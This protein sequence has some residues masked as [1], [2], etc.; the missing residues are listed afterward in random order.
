MIAYPHILSTILYTAPAHTQ[1]LTLTD[2]LLLIYTNTHWMD[3]YSWRVIARVADDVQSI[4]L[5][6]CL[7]PPKEPLLPSYNK[8][9]WS[10]QATI[11][12]QP[13]AI[14]INHHSCILIAPNA[15][16]FGSSFRCIFHNASR[17]MK[18]LCLSSNLFLIPIIFGLPIPTI[19]TIR[20]YLRASC[21]TRVPRRA[22]RFSR[23]PRGTRSPSRARCFLATRSTR[24]PSAT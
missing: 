9:R 6:L 12:H 17:N 2:P 21:C 7:R 22:C 10:D 5:V 11:S 14:L 19:P 3:E 20:E 16:F 4:L 24:A 8:A 1:V 23:W 13:I 18:I 15:H